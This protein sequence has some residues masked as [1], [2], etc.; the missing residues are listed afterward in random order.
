MDKIFLGIPVLNRLDLL[1][2]CLRRIDVPAQVY[3][4]N[5]NSV[6]V[7][8]QTDLARLAVQYSLQVFQAPRNLGVA[9][10][11][12]HLLRTAQKL[13]F[14][15][16]FVTANDFHLGPG[17]LG[18]FVTVVRSLSGFDLFLGDGFNLFSLSPRTVEKVG[19]FDE[20]FYPA[21]FEDNDYVYRCRLAKARILEFHEHEQ[22][23]AG[24]TIPALVFHHVGSQTV[25][26]DEG[27]GKANNWTF[28]E[29]NRTHYKMKWG[30]VPGHETFKSPYGKPNRD[31][32]W[33][34]HPGKSIDRRDWD[35]GKVRI[36]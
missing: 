6:D 28:P 26:S 14:D 36:R 24:Q 22:Q 11:W 10:S 21:Y 7:D 8:F 2:E 17:T 15:R 23:V 4:V 5:N 9:A 33:W 25:R 3:I 29:W 30:G 20:N 32:R 35:K 1:A 31:W 16:T 27:Y 19:W 12:N 18:N 13:G 34:P